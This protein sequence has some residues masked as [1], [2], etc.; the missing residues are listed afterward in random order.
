MSKLDLKSQQPPNSL[1]TAKVAS[2][3][4]RFSMC[5]SSNKTLQKPKLPSKLPSDMEG[6]GRRKTLW[7]RKQLMGVGIFQLDESAVDVNIN[8]IY[9]NYTYILIY[10]YIYMHAEPEIRLSVASLFASFFRTMLHQSFSKLRNSC[11]ISPS[12]AIR[13]S[14]NESVVSHTFSGLKDPCD[15]VVGLALATERRRFC[16]PQSKPIIQSLSLQ[17]LTH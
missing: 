12:D 2:S 10:I 5:Y 8:I 14:T 7:Q 9:Y 16:S 6:T 15:I 17:K 11:E 3:F 13:S 4:Q 1:Q